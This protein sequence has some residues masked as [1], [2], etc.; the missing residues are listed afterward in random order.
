MKGSESKGDLL[1]YLLSLWNKG[2]WL[3]CSELACSESVPQCEVLRVARACSEANG[4]AGGHG[5]GNNNNNSNNNNDDDDDDDDVVKIDKCDVERAQAQAHGEPLMPQR[6]EA[7]LVITRC[8][9]TRER[10]NA[11]GWVLFRA[12]TLT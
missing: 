12:V 4:H 10:I 11:W 2:A 6:L 5:Y 7:A 8:A 9:R 3:F 1:V